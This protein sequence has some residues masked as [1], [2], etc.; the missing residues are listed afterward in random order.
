VSNSFRVK[1]WEAR[2]LL[3]LI[4]QK[5]LTSRRSKTQSLDR[6]HHWKIKEVNTPKEFNSTAAHQLRCSSPSKLC[7]RILDASKTSMR[8]NSTHPSFLSHSSRPQLTLQG[9][10]KC[11][12]MWTSSCTNVKRFPQQSSPKTSQNGKKT[13]NPILGWSSN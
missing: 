11:L 2:E 1:V 10:T 13:T 5:F 12:W 7:R 9:S 8:L 4:I 3:L 6:E